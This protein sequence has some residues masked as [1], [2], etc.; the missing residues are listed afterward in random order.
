MALQMATD[1]R[2]A[3]VT[4]AS[5][6]IG[7]A[8][9][10]TIPETTDLL[11][12]G[13]D[14]ERLVALREE[15]SVGERTVESIPADLTRE[16]D[17]RALIDKA[18]ALEIDLLINNAGM[19]QFGAVLE[20]DP[21]GEVDTVQVNCTAVVDLAV[22]LLPGMIDRERLAG[23]RA[24]LINVSSTFAVQPIP[25]VATYA[26][27]KA[28]VQSWTEAL[29]EELRHQ[30]VDVLALCPGATRTGMAER[31]GLRGSIPFAGDP[32]DVAREAL[33]ALGR[34]TVHVS[35]AASR[36]ALTPY[37]LPRRIAAGGLGAVMGF[38]S[39]VGTR[40]T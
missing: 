32:E 9:A 25:Y 5:S 7:A 20:N 6:G 31:A 39:R 35:G 8:F 19:G 12:T 13:R 14:S 4:G 23:R 1:Y 17:R 37:F 40:R 38:F 21:Q 28:F 26:A 30:P 24:G 34:C 11:L 22:N 2:F 36:A 16:G 33:G 15:L 29:A 3:L 18:Q 10:R 27:S